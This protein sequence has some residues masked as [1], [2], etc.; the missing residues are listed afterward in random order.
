ME[1]IVPKKEWSVAIRINHWAMVLCIFTLIATGFYIADPFTVSAGETTEKF[2]MGDMRIIHVFCGVLLTFI[3]IW[4]AYL[5]FFSRFHAD[6]K[7]FFAWMDIEHTIKQIKFYALI[8]KEKPEHKMLYGPLQ[9]LA[10]GGLYMMLLLIVVTGLI[11][12]GAGVHSGFAAAAA[13]LLTPIEH[14]MGG[15][16]MVRWIHHILTWGFILFIV[17]HVYMAFWYDAIFQEGTVSSMIS[18]KVFRKSHD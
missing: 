6:W 8:S 2:I 7:D 3:F 9:S 11:L 13:W 16:A 12:T 4:R 5:A 17:A 1:H 15:L 10:Y 18:G 14:M